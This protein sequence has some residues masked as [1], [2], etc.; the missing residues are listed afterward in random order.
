VDSFDLVPQRS[1]TSR[2]RRTAP[3]GTISTASRAPVRQVLDAQ[4][5]VVQRKDDAPHAVTKSADA[6]EVAL[7]TGYLGRQIDNWHEGAR[8]GAE[9]F[10]KW[11]RDRAGAG[12]DFWFG[13][14]GNVLWA[15]GN[16]T[17]AG[18]VGI[19][20]G[21]M[22]A[23][24]NAHEASERQAQVDEIY[25]DVIK[26]INDA[27]S[28]MTAESVLEDQ[29][30]RTLQDSA[31]AS[32]VRE[33]RVSDWEPRVR[34]LINPPEGRDVES[35]RK[36]TLAELLKRYWE[37]NAPGEVEVIYLPGGQPGVNIASTALSDWPEI[38]RMI[39]QGDVSWHIYKDKR[40]IVT[41][42]GKRIADIPPDHPKRDVAERW[43]RDLEAGA[44]R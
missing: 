13:L 21:A 40:I 28:A 36:E 10:W 44:T 16:T 42:G 30:R 1:P 29:A 35:V 7:I 17:T 6:A 3:Q 24:H 14:A 11:S 31:L 38:V 34:N 22:V 26:S 41:A 12:K 39:Q 5:D 15:V 4:R 27:R 43:V 8:Q 2:P 18:L 23:Y 33:G 32:A 20:I 19:G 37:Q 25:G 9:S